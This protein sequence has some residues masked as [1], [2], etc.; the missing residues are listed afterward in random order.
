MIKQWT[1]N[2][3]LRETNY[4]GRPASSFYY[5]EHFL[6]GSSIHLYVADIKMYSF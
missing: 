5:T 1:V 6:V 2:F 4:T 3:D